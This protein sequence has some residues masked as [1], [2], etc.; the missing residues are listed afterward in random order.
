MLIYHDFFATRIRINVS[1]SGQMIRIQPHQNPKHCFEDFKLGC[2][3]I[4]KMEWLPVESEN[5]ILGQKNVSFSILRSFNP[6]LPFQ[7]KLPQLAN[8]HRETEKIASYDKYYERSSFSN[9]H[10]K[11][12]DERR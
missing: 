10:K 5:E 3:A 1:W 11:G 9:M 8:L 6:I 2:D 7:E 4:Q 12:R